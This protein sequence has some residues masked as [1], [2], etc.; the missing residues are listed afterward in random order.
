MS[1]PTAVGAKLT[2]MVQLAAGATVLHPLVA[3]VNPCPAGAI[4][5][6][7]TTRVAVPVLVTVTGSGV[8]VPVFRVPK[9]SVVG[10]TDAAGAAT[11]VPVRATVVG[12]AAALCAMSS[13]AACA[14]AVVG[15]K[16]T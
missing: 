7:E 6:P 5:A 2:V 12:E 14:V 3:I 11:P 9:A 8:V 16:A 10:L 15:A 13:V 4:V 1:A